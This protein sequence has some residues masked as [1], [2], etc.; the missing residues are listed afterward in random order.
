MFPP[1]GFHTFVDDISLEMYQIRTTSLD[2]MTIAGN[3]G[4]G[5]LSLVSNP[6]SGVR[7]KVLRAQ[8]NHAANSKAF[9]QGDIWYCENKYNRLDQTAL[10]KDLTG[11][12][13]RVRMMYPTLQSSGEVV[14]LFTSNTANTAKLYISLLANG[15]FRL[16]RNAGTLATLGTSAAAITPG[17]W[18]DLRLQN[19]TSLGNVYAAF[20]MEGSATWNVIYNGSQTIVGVG[21]VAAGLFGYEGTSSASNLIVYIDDF[22]TN[23]GSGIFAEIDRN[24]YI[25][26]SGCRDVTQ[27]KASFVLVYPTGLFKAATQARIEYSKSAD[28][29]NSTLTT[30]K[31]LTES[32][33]SALR[34]SIENLTDM[35]RYYYRFLIGDAN[36]AVVWT[37]EAYEFRTLPRAGLDGRIKH[38]YHVYSC[39]YNFA[40]SKP[41]DELEPVVAAADASNYWLGSINIGDMGYE[42]TG[43]HEAIDTFLAAAGTVE[44]EA[45]FQQLM[46]E[47]TAEITLERLQ[48]K[49]VCALIADD[50]ETFNDGNA[51]AR[52]G[53]SLENTLANNWASRSGTYGSTTTLGQL[54]ARGYSVYDAWYG[55]ALI[56]TVP[57]TDGGKYLAKTFGDTRWLYIDTRRE[58]RPDLNLFI[59][60]NQHTWLKGQLTTFGASPVEQTL[61]IFSAGGFSDFTAKNGESWEVNA[62]AQWQDFMEHLHDVVP[63]TKR[64]IVYAGDDHLGCWAHNKGWK[65]GGYSSAPP[66][67]AEVKT[68]G[69]CAGWYDVS[70]T[71]VSNNAAYTLFRYDDAGQI[72]NTTIVRS[73]GIVASQSLDSTS[74]LLNFWGPNSNPDLVNQSVASNTAPSIPERKPDRIGRTFY[75]RGF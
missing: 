71:E 62:A 67:A 14:L 29:S 20:R 66:F 19:D 30:W 63:T 47:T 25:P 41:N 33:H 55:N 43:F 24:W 53:G 18:F 28:F 35:S 39:I 52:P 60:V 46:R 16:K 27:T 10:T 42:H 37:S 32:Q 5:T 2:K 70:D 8:S 59:S 45:E 7:D 17:Q 34:F 1:K 49:G 38:D 61:V 51:N 13:I 21:T 6:G 54:W 15:T 69:V 31:S 74:H 12:R 22:A 75:K 64:V 11:T 65:D 57:N 9:I 48:R 23:R 56:D 50:H 36:N 58:R 40:A 26:G 68:S 3:N 72:N 73:S 4:S 44:T